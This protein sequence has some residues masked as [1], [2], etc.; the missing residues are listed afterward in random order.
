MISSDGSSNCPSRAD[1]TRVKPVVV[2]V[3]PV[4]R[5]FSIQR[6]RLG[7][8]LP[9][10]RNSE[11]ITVLQT[12]RNPRWLPVPQ[13]LNARCIPIQTERSC[14]GAESGAASNFSHVQ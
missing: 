9:E 3:C 11:C 10:P 4:N 5:I 8:R 13:L 6:F 12:T 1:R 2:L 14:I 7:K